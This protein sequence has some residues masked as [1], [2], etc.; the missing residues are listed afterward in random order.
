MVARQHHRDALVVRQRCDRRPDLLDDVRPGHAV[1]GV[2]LHAFRQLDDLAILPR[3]IDGEL[4]AASRTFGLVD[5]EAPD[6][7]VEPG[8]EAGAGGVSV[9]GADQAQERLLHEVLSPRVAATE[10]PRQEGEDLPGVGVHELMERLVVPLLPGHHELR[11]PVGP[12]LRGPL[13]A[14]ALGWIL[15]Q[16][17]DGAVE[18]PDGRWVPRDLQ[19]LSA[20][21]RPHAA[22]AISAATWPC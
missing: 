21:A 10:E 19:D 6:D 9:A 22:R 20:I 1:E 13:S 7:R 14:G 3:A 11:A 5:T 4:A 15:G 2:E 12:L 17:H 16:G 18:P 8:G